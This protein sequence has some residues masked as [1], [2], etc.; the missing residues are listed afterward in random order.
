MAFI[1]A[2]FG[3]DLFIK[4]LWIFVCIGAIVYTY[5]IVSLIRKLSEATQST[6]QER[7]NSLQSGEELMY[8]SLI[9][10]PFVQQLIAKSSF[11]NK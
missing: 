8:N 2:N 6:C 9:N 11:S 4:Y 1:D 10:S 3:N 7:T 5:V